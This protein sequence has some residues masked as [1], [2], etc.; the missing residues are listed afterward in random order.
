MF[1][2]NFWTNFGNETVFHI[3]PN[4]F[5]NYGYPKNVYITRLSG[6]NGEYDVGFLAPPYDEYSTELR[7]LRDQVMVLPVSSW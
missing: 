6:G 5:L 1:R 3:E 7:I 2:D 4:A